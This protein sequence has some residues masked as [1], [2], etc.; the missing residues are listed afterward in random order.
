M[1]GEYIMIYMVRHG[2]SA[3]NAGGITTCASDICL[4]EKGW[5]EARGFAQEVDK[6]PDMIIVSPFLR[7][8][9][10]SE[11]LLEKFPDVPVEVWDVQEFIFLG[12]ASYVNTTNLERRK[13]DAEY[14]AKD[15]PD[16]AHGEGGESFNQMMQR[17]DAFL[18]KAKSI[19]EDKYVLVFSHDR[20]IRGVKLRQEGISPSIKNLFALEPIKNTKTLKLKFS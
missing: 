13:W 17:V 12:D 20:F 8:Q 6:K 7:A 2:Q 4:S 9:Q 3:S 1:K 11:P 19:D 18:E 10:T 5:Q 16:Y 15:D 14:F